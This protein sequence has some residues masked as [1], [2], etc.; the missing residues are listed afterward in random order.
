[1][2][3]RRLGW[4]VH[5][6]RLKRTINFAARLEAVSIIVEGRNVDV[7]QC[8]HLESTT[9]YIEPKWQ[10]TGFFS[11]KKLRIK[12][13]ISFYFSENPSKHTHLYH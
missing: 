10:N 9:K 11:G 8:W 5:L 7:S 13:E 12:C 6:E 2:I 1:M 4:N 3:F